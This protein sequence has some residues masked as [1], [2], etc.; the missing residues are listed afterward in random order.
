LAPDLW[1]R[2]CHGFWG[3]DEWGLGSR[4]VTRL[5]VATLGALTV[6]PVFRMG[7]LLGGP[8][9]GFLAGLVAAFSRLYVDGAHVNLSDIPAAFFATLALM[10][11]TRLLWH[12]TRRDYVLGGLAAGLA[13]GAKY[14]AGLTA[15]ALVAA[16]L[17]GCWR[18]RRAGP[19]IVLA[20]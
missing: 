13:A 10:Y 19:E 8:A 7:E 15:I 20:G 1:M 4:L 17:R 12:E 5:T 2:V 11:A 6:I 3:V 9:A 16:W 14:P 18:S